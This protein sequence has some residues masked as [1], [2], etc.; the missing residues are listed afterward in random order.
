MNAGFR[1]ELPSKAPCC[2]LTWVSAGQLG[3]AQRVLN[4]T[5]RNGG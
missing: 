1:A 5:D 3:I 2:G 4:R